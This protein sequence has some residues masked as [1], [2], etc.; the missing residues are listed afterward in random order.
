MAALWPD[1]APTEADYLRAAGVEIPPVLPTPSAVIQIPPGTPPPGLQPRVRPR[2][3]GAFGN[4]DSI[5]NQGKP[6]PYATPEPAPPSAPGAV[7]SFME[8]YL[9]GRR[10]RPE[11]VVEPGAVGPGLG[12]LGQGIKET[13]SRAPFDFSD[14]TAPDGAPAPAPAGPAGTNTVAQKTR[15]SELTFAGAG[16]GGGNDRL[17]PVPD[18]AS[19]P[20]APPFS[21]TIRDGKRVYTNADLDQ[22][23]EG[24]HVGMLPPG[25]PS[26]FGSVRGTPGGVSTFSN[27]QSDLEEQQQQL[28]AL[29][30]EAEIAKAKA[31]AA[32]P[33]GEG[34]LSRRLAAQ[35]QLDKSMKYQLQAT[36][37]KKTQDYHAQAQKISST[38]DRT[39]EEI[40]AKLAELR[41]SYNIDMR[42]LGVKVPDIE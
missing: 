34:A 33:L 12:D 27:P 2:S 25:S 16:G 38:P 3:R 10:Q 8:K 21:P 20:P 7:Q 14:L 15:Q 39:P 31:Q 29:Q 41:T 1:A 11:D 18:W 40:A 36:I 26:K 5:L 23:H 19:P 4:R 35:Q 24:G 17:G 28:A 13:L 30:V 22:V 9:G 42:S 37:D 32:D 6:K